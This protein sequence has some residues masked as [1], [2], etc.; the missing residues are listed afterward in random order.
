MIKYNNSPLQHDGEL[1][2]LVNKEMRFTQ[3]ISMTLVDRLELIQYF[4]NCYNNTDQDTVLF[5]PEFK[6][7]VDRILNSYR[8]TKLHYLTDFEGEEK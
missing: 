5:A 3:D 8:P 2:S 4:L 7:V 6:I 1:I